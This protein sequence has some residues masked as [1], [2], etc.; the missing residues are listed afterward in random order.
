MRIINGKAA[1]DIR[2]RFADSFIN[3]TSEYYKTAIRETRMCSDG[4]CYLGRLWV[5][6]H[7]RIMIA[8]DKAVETAKEFP[9]LL[10]MWDLNSAD[11]IKI[12][13]YWKYPKRAVLQITPNELETVLPT[14]PEDVYVFDE[15]CT[16]VVA[17]TNEQVS[18]GRYCVYCQSK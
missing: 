7:E 10:I 2:R 8:E 16:R 12:P 11:R 18:K 3:R 1:D 4:M 17:F 9:K 13:G 14:L 15:D 6:F 5:C